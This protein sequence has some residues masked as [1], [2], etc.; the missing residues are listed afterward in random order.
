MSATYLL[1]RTLLYM[2]GR[3]PFLRSPMVDEEGIRPVD[4]YLWLG[5]VPSFLQC[6]TQ[7]VG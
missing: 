1:I 7:F 6:L 4:D 3:V 5:S 2:L